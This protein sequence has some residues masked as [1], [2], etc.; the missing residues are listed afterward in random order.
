MGVL[1]PIGVVL[2][3]LGTAGSGAACYGGNAIFS[4]PNTATVAGMR[5]QTNSPLNATS[6]EAPRLVLAPLAGLSLAVGLVCIGVG[7]GNWRRPIPTERRRANPWSDQPRE[8][9][10]PPV[11]QV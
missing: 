2:I 6:G 1:L 9:G 7:I 10:D 3:V 8:H 5:G 11:G 4:S